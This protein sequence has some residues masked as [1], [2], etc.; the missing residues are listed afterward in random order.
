MSKI[1]LIAKYYEPTLNPLSWN[2]FPDYGPY[3]T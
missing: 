1:V 3:T 2:E